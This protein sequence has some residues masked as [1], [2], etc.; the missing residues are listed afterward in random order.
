MTILVTGATGTIG[1]QV[2]A[3]LR[4]RNVQFHALVRDPGKAKLPTGV[5][6][7]R[8]EFLDVDAM[9]AALKGVSTVFLLN[10]VVPDELTQALIAL[11][12]AREAGVRRIVYLSV[13][14]SDLYTNVPH[15]AGKYAVERMIERLGLHATIL[16]PGYFMQ[17]DL[18]LRDAIVAHAIYPMPIGDKGVAM[19]DARDIGE[20]AAIELLRGERGSGVLPLDRIDLA[21]PDF[22]TG[23]SIAAIWSEVLGHPVAYA[24]N[25]IVPFE[26]TMRSFAPNWMAYDMRMMIE[27]FQKDGL[28]ARPGDAQRLTAML[29]RPLRSYREFASE[30]LADQDDRIV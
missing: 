17:N 13:M 3:Q 6:V 10:A 30:M 14:N 16:R 18:R 9:R 26:Q 11:N 21:G 2:V 24:G 8:G 1:T 25:D 15:F 20:V 12:L 19:V 28:S 7:V 4:A 23:S 5:D 22:L 29:G 27:R